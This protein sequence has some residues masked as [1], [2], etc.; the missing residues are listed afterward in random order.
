M[1]TATIERPPVI[2]AGELPSNTRGH[3]P[4]GSTERPQRRRFSFEFFALTAL[5]ALLNFADLGVNGWSNTYYSATVRSMTASWH[6][7][8]YASFDQSGVMTVDKPPL[9][10]WVQA[11][12]AKV[13]GFN[14]WGLLLPQ[15]LMGVFAVALLW[16]LTRRVWGRW[17]AFVAG[18]V[19]ALTPITVAI[20]RH[21][22]PD[23]LLALLS[24]L[25]LW[26]IVRAL[27][28]GRT[29][30]LLLSGLALGLAFETKMAAGLMTMPALAAAYLYAS[31]RGWTTAFE[32]LLAGGGVAAASALAWPLL[33]WLTPASERPWISGTNDNSIW[34]LILDY[35][36]AGRVSGQSGGPGGM[37]GGAGAGAGGGGGLFGGTTGVWRLFNTTLGG[38]AG[39]LLVFAAVSLAGILW[40]TR[41]RRD[42][43]R[44]GWAIAAGG[45]FLTIAYVFSTAKGIFHPYYTAQ[46]APFTA[47][48]AGAGFG[49]MRSRA[50]W[51]RLLAGGAVAATVYAQIA[52]AAEQNG[53]LRWLAPVLILVAL[54]AA[55]V[56]VM[57]PHAEW[58]EPALTVALAA[59]VLAP[60]AWSF[61]TVGHSLGSTFPA[62]GPASVSAQGPGGRRGMPG[63][64]MQGGAMQGGATQGGAMQPPGG[65]VNG[66]MQPPGGMPGG[67]PGGAGGS[68]LQPPPAM[69][70][71]ASG[72][73][74]PGAM[75][76]GG[77]LT[78]VLDY[79]QSHGGGTVAVS[80]QQGASTAII[81]SGANVAGIGGFSGRESEVSVDWLADRVRSGAIS[82][83]YTGSGG[84]G[85][86]R[87]G[88]TGSTTAMAAVKKAC[89]AVQLDTAAGGGSSTTSVASTNSFSNAGASSQ[90][91]NQSTTGTSS[92]VTLYDCR[93]HASELRAAD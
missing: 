75:F 81:K 4:T 69:S 58:H 25:A 89:T 55:I 6:N 21:N 23:A 38:Q 31:P 84:S 48:L 72:S 73:G 79:T 41:L 91:G 36:G 90:A 3:E 42:D 54:S 93:G 92:S 59:L 47:A 71:G 40:A 35:N 8:I 1:S 56:I 62:G 17:P 29:R 5:T 64:V 87:D 32:Q 53:E 50:T 13:F 51:V 39:W 77:D 80:G 24:V 30:W 14:T 61:Q 26:S 11:A 70:G 2:T 82:W 60:A 67:L 44:T 57:L 33:M 74:G 83:V 19:L 88:R 22:N 28:D 34:S 66:A 43:P 49:L 68:T 86:L 52:I 15:A 46:L 9:A 85:G 7:F 65:A 12:S 45:S 10:L 78:K 16:D 18:A 76:G 37:V 27:Q 63:G 20:S